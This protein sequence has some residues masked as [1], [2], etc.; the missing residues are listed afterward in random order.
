MKQITVC[1]WLVISIVTQSFVAIA[2]A[3]ID[4][5]IAFTHLE[6]E[7]VHTVEHH[8]QLPISPT[9]NTSII[10]ND[11]AESDMLEQHNHADCHHCGHCS[12][13]HAL[14]QLNT[15]IAVV[16]EPSEND[17]ALKNIALSD[18]TY[19]TYRPPIA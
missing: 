6:E 10:A 3:S 16:I 9:P 2:D 14:W 12:T 1:L 17:Y 5:D 19:N 11:M 13:P 18:V 8:D 15:M 7:H 4:L